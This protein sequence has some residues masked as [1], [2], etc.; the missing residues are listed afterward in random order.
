ML[1]CTS[2]VVT[3]STIQD[4]FIFILPLLNFLVHAFE[5]IYLFNPLYH[6]MFSLFYSTI[7]DY[8]I[9]LLLLLNLIVHAFEIIYL[10]HPLYHQMFSLLYLFNINM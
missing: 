2:S 6:S 4:Y 5:I 3:N 10:F 1:V 9:F 7:Q 8:F